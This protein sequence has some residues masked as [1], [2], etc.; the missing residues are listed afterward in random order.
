MGSIRELYHLQEIEIALAANEQ[1]QAKTLELLQDEQGVEA[2]RNRAAEERNRLQ[3]ATRS[4]KELEQE[5]E[6]L[7]QKIAGVNRKLY[8]GK[9]TNPKELSNLQTEAE[10]LKGKCSRLEDQAL[11]LMEKIDRIK[12]SLAAAEDHL[13]ATE[14]QRERQKQLLEA[15]L[16]RFQAEHT[17]LSRQK[18][19]LWLLFDA[20]TLE[21]YQ[22][23]KQRRGTAV[24]K[25]EQGTCRGCWI[26][27]S[28][29]E[30]QEAKGNRIVKCSSCG[31]ILYLP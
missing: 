29:G 1:A 7:S 22:S 11:E 17:Q 12:A 19:E 27:I 16:A 10:D 8:D 24:A 14:T 13:R 31:R 23:I 5:I 30:L 28:S 26:A 20:A 6:V 9:T 2:A 18:N 21:L 4:Q 3:Q 25:V 15:E